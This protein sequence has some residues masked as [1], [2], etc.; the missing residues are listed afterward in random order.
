MLVR[1]V[2]LWCGWVQDGWTDIIRNLQVS[3]GILM[4]DRYLMSDVTF[5]P[6]A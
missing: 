4:K 3:S 6:V 2:Q 5:E 1:S